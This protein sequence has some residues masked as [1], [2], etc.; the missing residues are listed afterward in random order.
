[1]VSDVAS[2][3]V[4]D[5][6]MRFT[7]RG[8][9]VAALAAATLAA[10]SVTG[11][12]TGGT[13][14]DDAQVI[15][16]WNTNALRSAGTAGQP[17]TSINV[18]M[19]MVHGAIY[20]A[21]VSIAGGYTPYLGAIEADAGASK[22]AAAAAAAHGVLVELFPDQ[23]ADL[24]A[25]LETS[26]GSVPDGDAKDAGIAVG[27]AAAAAMLEAREGDG[28]GEPFPLTFGDGPGEYRPTPPDF[29]E[30]PDAGIVNVRM[31]LADDAEYYRTD[32]PLALDSP[33]YAAEFEEVRTL[34]GA[35]GSSRTA[36]QDEIAAFWTAAIPQWSIVE[37][38]LTGER[39]LDIAEAARLFAIA[40]LAAADASI[41]CHDDKYHWM[42]WRPVTAIH[43]AENDG[44]PA[45]EADPEWVELAGGSPPYPDHPSGFNCYTGAHA[46]ALRE[47]FGTDDLAFQVVHMGEGEPRSFASISE[48]LEEVI[49]VRI[50]QGLHFRTAEVQGSELGQKA[51]A[52][53]A[54]R[55][56][57]VE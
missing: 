55:L 1:M 6:S 51:A 23:A 34:G 3:R 32:G 18:S 45:T 54:E 40:N 21:V 13:G 24:D 50:Y 12:V 46:G 7:I 41:A 30:Y 48:A 37:R 35:E 52:V 14:D 10:A 44:N 43:E 9:T 16:D 15:V 42:F 47:F 49:D 26:L 25:L 5:P 28:R 17:P 20:D 38:T 2:L 57:A 27:Q 56:A 29:L 4:E 8:R 53:A 19:G 33:E 39:D 36:E 22:V 31:F 11:P